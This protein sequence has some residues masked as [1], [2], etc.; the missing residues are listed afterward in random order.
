MGLSD[1]QPQPLAGLT[2]SSRAQWVR[3]HP[4]VVWQ[5]LSFPMDTPHSEAALHQLT[6]MA[7]SS[8]ALRD[9]TERLLYLSQ[10]MTDGLRPAT[11]WRRFTGAELLAEVS[12]GPWTQDIK[13]VHAFGNR[14]RERLHTLSQSLLQEQRGLLTHTREWMA[15]AQTS[16]EVLKDE[17][18]HIHWRHVLGED[19]L[20]RLPQRIDNLQALASTLELT[21][22]QCGL[23]VQQ[24]QS[25]Q[26]RFEALQA[27]TV[28]LLRQRLTLLQQ[29]RG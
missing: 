13:Q 20:Q 18:T 24:A 25:L 4:Q 10:A 8:Q 12:H 2:R 5:R 26:E 27:I 21:A 14:Q 3:D 16:R 28:P 23:A 15:L 11:W 1:T 22:H 17:H 7:E 19:A 29:R 9:F 6:Q